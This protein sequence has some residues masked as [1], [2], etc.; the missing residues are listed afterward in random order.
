VGKSAAGNRPEVEAV[1]D[2]R[3]AVVKKV[4]VTAGRIMAGGIRRDVAFVPTA[5]DQALND[6][7]DDAYRAKYVDSP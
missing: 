6:R 5:D 3:G 2:R 1:H 4:R 7:I